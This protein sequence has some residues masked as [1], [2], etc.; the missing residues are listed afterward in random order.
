VIGI[1]LYKLAAIATPVHVPVLAYSAFFPKK[2]ASNATSS[3]WYSSIRARVFSKI[4]LVW[5][6][7]WGIFSG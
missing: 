1:F 5:S 4:Y 3:G 6:H 2:G 7:G